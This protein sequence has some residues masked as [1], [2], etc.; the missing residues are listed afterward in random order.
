MIMIVLT[1]HLCL[2]VYLFNKSQA[3]VSIDQ[4]AA[5]KQFNFWLLKTKFT[6]YRIKM[7]PIAWMSRSPLSGERVAAF[8]Q[9]DSE[10][11]PPVP[12]PILESHESHAIW[13][14]PTKPI[15]ALE[16]SCWV[17]KALK[18]SLLQFCCKEACEPIS[19]FHLS[20]PSE[21][22]RCCPSSIS[23]YN[24]SAAFFMTRKLIYCSPAILI[25]RQILVKGVSQ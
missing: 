21:V 9:V 13:L 10:C 16:W 8:P 5:E 11:F 7:Y 17:Q 20:R 6:S 2:Q 22:G 18:P 3:F 15:L 1:P 19:V 23:E 4:V 12:N 24:E 25:P 14:L